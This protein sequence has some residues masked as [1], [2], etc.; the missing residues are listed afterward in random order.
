MFWLHSD[1]GFRWL[2]RIWRCNGCCLTDVVLPPRWWDCRRSDLV[3]C[4]VGVRGGCCDPTTLLMVMRWCCGGEVLRCWCVGSDAVSVWLMLCTFSFFYIWFSDHFQICWDLH[5]SFW[6]AVGFQ[7]CWDLQVSYIGWT[8][9]HW[10]WLLVLFLPV[11]TNF[12][13]KKLLLGF[14]WAEHFWFEF[15]S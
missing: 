5:D 11:S 14:W 15:G 13:L 4:L 10:C 2:W 7:I 9:L 1:F 8:L 12:Q 6:V 3:C